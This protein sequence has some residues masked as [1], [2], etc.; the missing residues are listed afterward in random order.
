M[1]V[2]PLDIELKGD[3]NYINGASFYEHVVAYLYD[4]LPEL[5]HGAFKMII[6]AFA[7]K[8]CTFVYGLD[9][10]MAKPDRARVEV[11]AST[12]IHGWVV[13][14]DNDVN[15]RVPFPEE[16][17]TAHCV[18]GE[19]RSARM[20]SKVSFLPIEI[21][22]A[23]TKKLHQSEFPDVAGKWIFTRIDL[24]RLLDES[25]GGQL[26][27]KIQKNIGTRLTQSVVTSGDVPIGK[28]YFS[29]VTEWPE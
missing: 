27:V 15:H 7:T 3:R 11:F 22:V 9:E 19:D 17:I 20:V 14:S 12:G 29:M 13:E 4:A 25:D 8:K 28:I 16:E 21:L 26:G 6:H 24:D 10:K 18:L 5:S 2:V 1:R 23:I